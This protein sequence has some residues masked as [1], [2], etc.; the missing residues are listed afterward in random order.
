MV[1]VQIGSHVD[2]LTLDDPI[3]YPLWEEVVRLGCALFVHPWDMG[4]EARLQKYWFPWLLG[5]PH[6]TSIA[7]ASMVMGGVFKKFPQIRVCYAHGGGCFP[8]LIG[9]I[10]HGF[11]ARP[12][13]CQGEC[14]E[15]PASFLGTFWVDSLVHDEDILQLLLKKVGEDRIILGSDYPFPLGEVERP[16]SLIERADIPVGTKQKLLANNAKL[17]LGFSGEG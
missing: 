14:E 1:G 2:G 9:R 4:T 8:Y 7:I 3:F 6:E 13:L 10:S 17:F 16:G 12:D 15:D 11:R 5:M